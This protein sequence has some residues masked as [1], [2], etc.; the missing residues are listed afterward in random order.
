M[1]N[2]ATSPSDASSPGPP[3]RDHADNASNPTFAGSEPPGN[4]EAG[5]G[6]LAT[7]QLDVEDGAFTVD[8]ALLSELL[9]VSQPEVPLLMRSGETASICERGVAAIRAV[10]G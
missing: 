4:E 3:G 8:A 5:G 6:K 2:P 10:S 7:P 9:G 1:R